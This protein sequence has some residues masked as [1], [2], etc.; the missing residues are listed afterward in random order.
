MRL[1]VKSE[2]DA[3]RIAYGLALLVALSVAVRAAATPLAG[4]A[5]LAGGLVGAWAWSCRS[6]VQTA[7]NHCARRRIRC[8]SRKPATRLVRAFW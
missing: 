5:V 3:F 2:A 1:P 8:R 7:N 4:V 6:R